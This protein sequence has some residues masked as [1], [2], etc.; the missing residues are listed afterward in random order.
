MDP[1]DGRFRD[2]EQLAN[3]A[4]LVSGSRSDSLGISAY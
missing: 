2:L 1:S 4:K 3:L